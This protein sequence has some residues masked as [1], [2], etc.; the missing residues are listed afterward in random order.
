MKLRLCTVVLFLLGLSLASPAAGAISILAP[1]DSIIA[2]DT[3]PGFSNS[4][5]PTPN[6][7]PQ[8]AIDGTPAK[9]LNFGEEGSGFIV[10]PGG[11]TTVL[12]FRLTTANDAENRDPAS[13]ELY[14]TTDSITSQDNS[15][16]LNENWFSIASGALA[17]PGTRDTVGP[18]VS[19]ANANA[20]TSYRMVFPSVKDAP[21]GDANSMQIREVEFFTSSDAST[22]DILDP[23]DPIIA[24]DFHPSQ[25]P[26]SGFPGGEGP[27]NSIDQDVNSMYLNFGRENS[28]FIVTPS[29]GPT[30]VQQF[31]ITTA[32]D[33]ESRDPATWLLYGT[34][35][36]IA[37]GQ[38][39]QGDAESWLLIDSGSVT[40]PTDRFTPGPLVSVNNDT[41]Y[42]SYR[43]VFPTIRD[44][45]AGDADSMQIAEVQFYGIVPEASSV[46]LGAI[47]LA[48]GASFRQKRRS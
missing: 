37:S 26:D 5:Y 41:Q 2:I 30:V 42:A 12:S 17:L 18:L 9:Y 32:N 7:T 31:Q 36:A 34:N 38:N 23:L 48:F 40:L 44:P 27:L 8:K 24:I 11:S 15:I 47:A 16:G 3:D 45:N 14:G 20:Y 46:V 21:G 6:E 35:D 22:P 29:V 39:S 43:M 10:T 1:G 25:S 28:G 19:F 13:F 33:A 4:G